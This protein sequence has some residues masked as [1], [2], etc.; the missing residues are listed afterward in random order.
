VSDTSSNTHIFL[1]PDLAKALQPVL[2][3]QTGNADV[4][5]MLLPKLH[6][7]SAKKQQ[8]LQKVDHY[9]LEETHELYS[10]L[11]RFCDQLK[12]SRDTQFKVARCGNQLQVIGDFNRRHMLSQ[13]V[14]QDLWFV[15]SFKWLQPNYSS[16]AHS[17]ELVE[18]SEQYQL[19]P[20]DAMEKYSHFDMADKG[21]AFALKYVD[22]TVNAQVES[23]VNLYCV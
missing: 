22:G 19:S 6:G 13:L 14:N 5:E 7:V 18:F 8:P 16:L 17:F 3:G 20:D 21:L 10:R 23:P 12:I 15:D 4:L 1:Q 2:A 11:R 9:M